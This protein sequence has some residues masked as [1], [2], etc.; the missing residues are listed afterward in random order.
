MN[1]RQTVIALR[2]LCRRDLAMRSWA[3]IWLQITKHAIGGLSTVVWAFRTVPLFLS[4]WSPKVLY[5]LDQVLLFLAI[6]GPL[7]DIV[8]GLA[9]L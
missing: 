4:A 1:I 8:C 7:V 5:S 9:F 3:T 2:D 6:L